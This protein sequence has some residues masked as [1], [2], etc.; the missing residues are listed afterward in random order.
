MP[1]SHHLIGAGPRKVLV[2]HGWFGSA[3]SWSPW[4]PS[5]DGHRF[6]YCFMDYRGYGG[7]IA[8]EGDYS[9]Q[10]IAA[11]ALALADALGWASFDLVG[12][13]MGGAAIQRVLCEA[14]GRIRR[15]VAITP[16]PASG[17]PFDEAGLQL[18]ASAAHSS[19]AR[20]TIL[21]MS[22]GNRLSRHWIETMVRD[23]LVHSKA[24]AFAR[25][26]TAWS[27]ADFAKRI[28]G[29]TV[30]VKVIV[31]GHDPGL[32]ADFMRAT[33]LQH[34]PNAVLEVMANAGHYPMYETPLALA[35][36]VE[37]HLAKN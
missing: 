35:A 24:E 14:P 36:S 9:L 1:N 15:M 37:E 26:F 18:F 12:H 30:P 33:F 5:L 29:S 8:T 32:N 10:E 19:S 16:V 21:D 22:T 28:T 4:L 27:R 6:Q 2:L 34:Y 13:S 25:Y 7:E 17:V 20:A 3:G 11:D 31:G 23:S